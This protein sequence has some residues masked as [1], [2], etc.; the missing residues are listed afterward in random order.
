M[1]WKANTTKEEAIERNGEG[2]GLP[3]FES[4]KENK[5]KTGPGHLASCIKLPDWIWTGDSLKA[6]VYY[7]MQATFAEDSLL[8]LQAIIK[9]GGRATDHEVKD[10]FNDPDKWPASTVSARRNYFMGNPYY[11]IKGYPDKLKLGPRNNKVT[12]WYVD[13]SRLYQLIKSEE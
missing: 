5:D 12:T 8:Y 10:F 3:L 6:A 11:I 9:L 2:F 1:G 7:R 4:A 13:F